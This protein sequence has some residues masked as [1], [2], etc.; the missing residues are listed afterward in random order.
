MQLW[1]HWWKVVWQLRPACSRLRTFLWFATC[2]AA[3]AIRLDG[4]GVTSLMRALGLKD[5]CYD[6]LLDFFHSQALNLKALTRLWVEVLL[7]SLPAPLTVNGRIILVGDGLKVPKS[8]KKMPAVKCLHQQSESNTKPEYIMGH[9]LQAVALLAGAHESPFAIPLVSRIHEGVIFSNRDRRTLLDKMVLLI[10]SLGVTLPF[11]FIADAY[12]ATRTVFRGLL[13][14]GNH[15]ISRVRSNAVAY[16]PATPKTSGKRKGR[17]PK[18]GQKVHLRSFFKDPETMKKNSSPVYGESGVTL[19]W[20]SVDLLWRPVGVLLRFV[21]V[22]H[23]SRGKL[24]L[25]CSDLTLDPLQIIRL[26]AL[27]FKIEISFKQALRIV[28]TYAYHFWMMA[29]EPIRRLSGNQHL[30]HKSDAYRQAVRRKIDAY[31]RH[32]QT[33]LIAQGLL[34][35][36]AVAFPK[37]VWN[38]FG[39]WIRT[40][41]PCLCPS[42]QVSSMSLRNTLPEFLAVSYRASILTKFLRR[43]IDPSRSEGMRLVA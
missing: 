41:R 33:G 12:Y 4:L 21:F 17:Q 42:E 30:H 22:V 32:I 27:R 18:Y 16:Y 23:P 34:Q 14:Q 19:R 10:Q 35:Y 29:M 40:I 9:S 6:R 25:A 3:M 38:N 7:A 13:A 28:G 24:I 2:L 11:Y 5:F 43:R 20:R 39:S 15:L 8:G 37:L 26:Y 1:I 36:L 31:H